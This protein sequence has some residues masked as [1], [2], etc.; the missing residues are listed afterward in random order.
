MEGRGWQLAAILPTYLFP[1][2]YYCLTARCTAIACHNIILMSVIALSYASVTQQGR[3]LSHPPPTALLAIILNYLLTCRLRLPFIT[4][5][6]NNHHLLTLLPNFCTF[7]RQLLVRLIAPNWHWIKRS[8]SYTVTYLL[9][10]LISFKDQLQLTLLSPWRI[11]IKI[12]KTQQRVNGWW[13]WIVKNIN[14]WWATHRR[15]AIN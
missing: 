13:G 12:Y 4:L 3:R 8:R 2:N 6:F 5:L 9:N 10:P 14:W 15:S 7:P 11:K 1:C